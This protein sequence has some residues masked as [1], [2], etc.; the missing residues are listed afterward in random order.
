MSI[1]GMKHPVVLFDVSGDSEG[2]FGQ[3]YASLPL[4]AEKIDYLLGRCEMFLAAKAA[5]PHLQYTREFE[6]SVE[7]RDCGDFDPG[8]EVTDV[9]DEICDT[10]EVQVLDVGERIDAC[11]MMRTECDMLNMCLDHPDRDVVELRWTCYPKHCDI[12]LET[13]A[14]TS[15]QLWEWA[16][17]LQSSRTP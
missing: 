7:F 9:L 4:T 15:T 12:E 11:E 8:D 17:E 2:V 3:L 14:I 6:Y 5:Y 16:R 13:T 1:S 10:A